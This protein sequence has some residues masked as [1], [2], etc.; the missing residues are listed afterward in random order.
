MKFALVCLLAFVAVAYV[1]ARPEEYT[2]KYDN[3]DIDQILNNDRL[4]KRYADCLLERGSARCPP[5][6]VELKRV[7]KEALETQ[8]EKCNDHQKEVVKKVVKF[9]S[10]KKQDIWRDLKAKYDPEGK[11]SV[12]YEEMARK[13]GIQ[14]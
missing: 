12:N 1:Y 8:C 6:A 14:L 11:Y 10:E 2:N 13:E 5:E 9:L 4:L 7:L 3:I